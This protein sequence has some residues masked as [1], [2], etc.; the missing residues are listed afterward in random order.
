M[1]PLVR[2]YDVV[3]STVASERGDK[4]RPR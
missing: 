3:D 4:R 2:H 1:E